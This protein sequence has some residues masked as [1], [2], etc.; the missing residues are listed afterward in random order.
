MRLSFLT[1][2]SSSCNEHFGA[3]GGGGGGGGGGVVGKI[4]IGPNSI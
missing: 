1:M 3:G 2:F 4:V